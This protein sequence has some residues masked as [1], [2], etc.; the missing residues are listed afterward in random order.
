MSSKNIILYNVLTR[1]KEQ[2]KSLKKGAV[3]LYTCGPT[4]YD[5]AHIGNLRTYIFEDVLKRTLKYNG[6]KVR[7]VMNITD[8]EDKIIKK[9]LAEKKDINE[10]TVPYTKAF[11]EDLQKLNIEKATNYPKATE[12]IKEMIAIISKLLKKG[13]AYKGE[14]G[15]IYFE[16]SKFKEYGQLS[17]LKKRSIKTGARISSDEYDKNN[18]QDFVLWK[19]HKQGEPSWDS[20]WGAGRPGWHIECSAMSMK[21]LGATFDIHA[22]G[23]D[24]VFPHHENEIAQSQAASG[25]KFV[26]YWIEGEHLMVNGKK[27]SKSL[28]NFYTLRDLEKN[29]YNPLAFRYLMLTSHYRSP[30]NFTEKSM[31]SGQISLN[32]LYENIIDIKKNTT[33]KPRTEII[34]KNKE[35]IVKIISNDIDT[36]GLL[37]WL[38]KTI[39]NTKLNN[40]EKH[41]LA[42]EADKILGLGLKNA[43]STENQMSPALQ[44]LVQMREKLRS[45]KKWEEADTIRKKINE[46]GWAVEDTPNGSVTKPIEKNTPK[47]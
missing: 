20:P 5:Y 12:H 32:H 8:V 25:K 3:G 22:G 35:D 31:A 38:W 40:K 7:H 39:K 27:M 11:L 6:Y 42:I 34:N 41:L 37:G 43:P 29:N 1:K 9:S 44:H 23:V 36:P 45:E 26:N 15:S 16:I 4:V 14:D 10:V 33:E 30:L 17:N 2:F 19:A 46:M 24:L 21:Y 13:V 47:V 28:G 18:A